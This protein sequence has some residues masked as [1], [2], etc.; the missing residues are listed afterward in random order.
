MKLSSEFNNIIEEEL[1]Q[2]N[3]LRGLRK[4]LMFL[5]ISG[6]EMHVISAGEND[7]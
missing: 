5:K 7:Q 4:F 2:A 6:K 1:Y 3:T